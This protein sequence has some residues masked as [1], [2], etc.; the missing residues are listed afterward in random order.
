MRVTIVKSDNMVAVDGEGHAVDCSALPEGFHALQWDGQ[1]GEVEYAMTRC[2]HCG[3]RTKKGNE[4]VRDLSTY[5]PYVD[6][7]RVAK[8]QADEAKAL[9]APATEQTGASDAAGPQG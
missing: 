9:F 4:F 2:D 1:S 3:A 5:Q 7:W 8:A 6:A